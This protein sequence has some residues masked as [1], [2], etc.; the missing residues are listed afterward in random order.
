MKKDELDKA[1]RMLAIAL[2]FPV[3]LVQNSDALFPEREI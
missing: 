1:D 3:I 2:D